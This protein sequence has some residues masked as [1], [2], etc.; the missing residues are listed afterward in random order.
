MNKKK[1]IM[2]VSAVCALVAVSVAALTTAGLA[3]IDPAS[4]FKMKLQK[5]DVVDQIFVGYNNWSYVMKNDGSYFYDVSDADHNGNNAGGEFPRGSNRTIV[6][7]AGMYIG[8][9]KQTGT[10]QDTQVVTRTEFATEFRPGFITNRNVPFR[11]LIKDNHL[12]ASNRVYI[13]HTPVEGDQGDWNNWPG[14]HQANGDPALIGSA[15]TWAVFNDV[16]TSL[17]TNTV[18]PLPGIGVEVQLQSIAI[19]AGLLSDVVFLR[20]KI[21][22][23]TNT[24]YPKSYIGLWMDADVNNSS[25]DI[26]GVDTIAGLGYVYDADNEVV[27]AAT[28]FDFFQG[29]VVNTADVS[30]AL[31]TRFAGNNTVL[32]YNPTT[33]AFDVTTLPGGKIW[34]GA[35]SF[36]TYAN[37]TD[38]ANDKER[39]YLLEGKNKTTGVPKTGVGVN[40][41]YAFPGNPLTQQGTVHVASP[42]DHADQRILHGVGPFTM[43]AND[44]IEMWAGVVGGE[45]ANRLGAFAVM[46]TTDAYAQT[47]FNAGLSYPTAP[48]VP[49]FNITAANGV[50]SLTWDN[51][52]EYSTNDVFGQRAGLTIA[53][54]YS[55][56]Y[57]AHDFQGYRVYRSRTG[58]P[59]SY[60]MLAQYDLID[61]WVSESNLAVDGNGY[62]QVQEVVF[63]TDNGL[64]YG[65]ADHDVVNGQ[66]YYY[67]VASYDAQHYIGIVGSP[68]SMPGGGSAPGPI[69]MPISLESS[70]SAN[71]V[72]VVPQAALAGSDYDASITG[73]EHFAGVSDGIWTVDVVDPSKI[74][75]GTYTLE[76]FNLPADSQGGT[77]V[78]TTG[79][80]LA[81]QIRFNG[82]VAPIS[83]HIDNPA[84]FYDK[85]SNGTYQVGIDIPLDESTYRT[86]QASLG[87]PS[88]QLPFMVDGMNMVVY[89]APPGIKLDD[90]FTTDDESLWGWS[91]PSGVRRFTW[92]NADGFALES[93]NGALTWDRPAHF[94][95]NDPNKYPAA[96]LKKVLL[97]LAQTSAAGVFSP[98]DPNASY[99]YRYLRGASPNYGLQE[100]AV[101]MPMAAFDIDDPNNPRRL[102]LGYLENLA[103]PALYVDSKYW[104]PFNGD[105]TSN[106]AGNSAREWLW[107]SDVT[108]NGSTTDASLSLPALTTVN[109]PYMYFATWNRRQAAAWSPGTSGEDQFQINPTKV[110]TETDK[111]RFTGTANTVSTAKADVKSGMKNIKV[112]PN[113][114][115]GRSD[116]QA[117]LFDKQVKF[118]HLPDVC[119]I[120]IFTVSGDLVTTLTH[121]DVSN[122]NRKNT[123][124]LNTSVTPAGAYTSTEVWNLQNTGGKYVASGMY[125]AV[126][127]APGKGKQIVKFAVIQEEITINGPDVR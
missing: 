89:G 115:Y 66:A 69:G 111:Y 98:T 20:L 95:G 8:T 26:V 44:S 88:T 85:N 67:S 91:I 114:Y 27:S 15:V 62:N 60:T 40:Y 80:V 84:T 51:R 47:I 43:L 74:R 110:L 14:D 61:G 46:K 45:G 78:G 124:P 125:V 6:F 37:G 22:N 94:F 101:S 13:V 38:P 86:D 34:L 59:G 10:G 103:G 42:A 17:A 29:P 120:K 21:I 68:V 116:Y 99:A 117:S 123:N 106:T 77:L 97:K 126:I 25:N 76:F 90:Q 57:I 23:K 121:N 41:K 9:I 48:D 36:N 105:V 113:P 71:V 100:Y 63:G 7:A 18:D 28:G 50:V 2:L 102:Q 107:I 87:D 5:P 12:A 108:Y 92:A 56:N 127:E 3:K 55:A 32:T 118:T 16:D 93:F 54:G 119:T 79:N 109:Q 52:V 4:S 104:P 83:S 49:V 65:Y 39:Y 82:T 64:H 70:L 11:Q 72:K 53:N 58:L 19:D 1:I 122:N 24:N 81:Y 75:T 73:I 30:A 33:N 96:S 35:T 112:V 31:A